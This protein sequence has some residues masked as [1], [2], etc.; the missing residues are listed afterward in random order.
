MRLTKRAG[1]T[2]IIQKPEIERPVARREEKSRAPVRPDNILDPE[3]G[4]RQDGLTTSS[5]KQE[6]DGSPYQRKEI[7]GSGLCAGV[8]VKGPKVSKYH[9]IIGINTNIDF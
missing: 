7:N 2:D 4:H 8:D 1:V 9:S 6:T 3:A 5:A